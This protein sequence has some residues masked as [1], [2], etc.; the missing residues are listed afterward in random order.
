MNVYDIF[1]QRCI[2]LDIKN[3]NYVSTPNTKHY[4]FVKDLMILPREL[5]FTFTSNI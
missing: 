2:Y 3:I 1:T 4:D 5:I